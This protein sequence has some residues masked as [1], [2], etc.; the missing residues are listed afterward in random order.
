[1]ILADDAMAWIGSINFTNT[2]LRYNFEMGTY[3]QDRAVIVRPTPSS[4]TS[5]AS[6][7]GRRARPDRLSVGRCPGHDRGRSLPELNIG[8]R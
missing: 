4:T 5:S 3:A 6:R 1:M 8:S 2:N 7:P